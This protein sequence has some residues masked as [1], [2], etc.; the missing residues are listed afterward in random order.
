MKMRIKY[1]MTRRRHRRQRMRTRRR[2]QNQIAKVLYD[3]YADFLEPEVENIPML[4]NHYKIDSQILIKMFESPGSIYVFGDPHH[5]TLLFQMLNIILPVLSPS[6]RRMLEKSHYF[7]EVSGSYEEFQDNMPHSTRFFPVDEILNLNPA[8]R[9]DEMMAKRFHM[10]NNHWSPFISAHL[11]KA[12]INIISLGR[13]HL[14]PAFGL[15]ENSA[16]PIAGNRRTRA[17]SFQHVFKTHI[18]KKIHTFV[19]VNPEDPHNLYSNEDKDL[20]RPIQANI[21]KFFF[22]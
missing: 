5:G 15:P 7:T 16:W 22:V 13:S 21:K 9:N 19:V 10:L 12:G 18:D 2:R 20:I 6:Q 17:E 14:Y 4:K 8:S 1:R 11:T 3:T